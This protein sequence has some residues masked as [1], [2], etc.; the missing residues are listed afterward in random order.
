MEISQANHK[1]QCTC[2]FCRAQRGELTGKNNPFYGK[3]HTDK[4]KKKMCKIKARLAEK[5]K[6]LHYCEKMFKFYQERIHA[7]KDELGFFKEK[8]DRLYI[9][10]HPERNKKEREEL[11]QELT[12]QGWKYVDSRRI[13]DAPFNCWRYFWILRR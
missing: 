9:P 11:M 7:L 13:W 3:K 10:Y 6:Q 1:S 2:S 8:G 5:K 12:S 4:A